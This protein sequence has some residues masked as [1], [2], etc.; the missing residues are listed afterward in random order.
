V[1]VFDPVEPPVDDAAVVEVARRLG[2]PGIIDIHVHLLPERL[3]ARIWAYFDSA[4]PL[5]GR[6]WPIRYRWAVPDLVSHLQAMSVQRFS[7]MPYAHKPGMAEGLCRH[8]LDLAEEFPEVLP[9]LTFFPEPD[10]A[11]Y[12]ADALAAGAR[13]GKVH[14]QVGDFD[15]REPVLDPVWG[16]LADAGIPVVIHAG[17]GPMAGRYTG[18]ALISQVLARHPGL[19]AV[20]A[21]LGAPE[22]SGFLDLVDEH[23]N[24]YLDTTMS[25]T[26]FMNEMH[27]VTDDEIGRLAAVGDRILFGSDLPSIPYA[28][29]HAVDSLVGLGMSDDWLRAVLWGNAARLLGLTALDDSAG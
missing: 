6:P 24:V 28:Y 10:A 3:Q 12:V 5:L 19:V 20:I 22:T 25:F 18:P 13:V 23:D 1:T 9:T 14:L 4:G 2:L 17:S 7:T 26:R 29:A 21:H 15:P 27:A 16:M 11:S 8:S